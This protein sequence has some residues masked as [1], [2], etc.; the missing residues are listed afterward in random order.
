MELFDKTREQL[1]DYAKKMKLEVAKNITDDKLREAVQSES[2]RLTI[3]FEERARIKLQAEAKMKIDIA[4]IQAEAKIRGIHIEIP[5]EP[6]LVDLA[7]LKK[8]L[9]I[10]IK[11]PKPSPETLAIEKSK[12]VYAIFRNLEQKNLD[13]KF[14]PGGKY[15]F[16]LWPG[17]VHVIPEY[18]IRYC[19][20]RV[21]VP[22][23]EKKVLQTLE[24]AKVHDMVESSVRSGDEQR[25]SFEILG[26][27]PADASFGLVSDQSILNKLTQEVA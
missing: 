3:E 15:W 13:V 27:A 4:E 5:K 24:T 18:L 26:D 2:I 17:K 11:E 6:T 21:K 7:G 9:N 25:W 14:C 22:N 10:M 23:Y 16:S 8:K 12:K 1:L 19:R 20:R